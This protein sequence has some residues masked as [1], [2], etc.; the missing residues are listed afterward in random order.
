MPTY[1]YS[2][3]ACG[4]FDALRAIAQR[5]QAA[6]CPRCGKPAPRVI[7]SGPHLVGDRSN[8]GADGSYRRMRHPPACQCCP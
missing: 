3:A 5:D 1:D 8:R 7:G 6:D 2:C 4:P